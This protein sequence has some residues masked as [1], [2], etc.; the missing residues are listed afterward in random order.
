[1]PRLGLDPGAYSRVRRQVEK[2]LRRRL[3]QLHVSGLDDY[4]RYLMK[5]DAEWVVLE[6]LC[7]IT[8]SRFFRD[9]AVFEAL[10]DFVLPRLAAQ[11]ETKLRVW[12]AGCGA[13][14][15]PYSL[16]L[17]WQY[18]VGPNFPGVELEIIA[19]DADAHQLERARAARYRP[20]SFRETPPDIPA[21]IDEAVT[22]R[23]TFLQQD[24]RSQVA[25]GPFALIAC[26]NLAFS[27]FDTEGQRRVL[28]QFAER[29]V[30][31]G[32]LMIGLNERLPSNDQFVSLGE[33]LFEKREAT[34]GSAPPLE[35]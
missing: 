27:Y 1:M 25:D 6:G 16:A 8:I 11:A 3:A 12:S 2:R 23:V 22:R 33:C 20:S 10:S 19:T 21:H 14:E 13:G 24:L 30:P 9:R 26:R 18:R 31:R 15:E 28:S 32:V 5:H 29:L 7:H 17:L 4:A 34:E 35:R